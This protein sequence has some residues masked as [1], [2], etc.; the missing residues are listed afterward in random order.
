MHSF[1]FYKIIDN[2]S[3]YM[4]TYIDDVKNISQKCKN[5]C[6]LMWR[7]PIVYNN[8][9]QKV[10]SN[11][12]DVPLKSFPMFIY[13]HLP[14]GTGITPKMLTSDDI[15]GVKYILKPSKDEYSG[16]DDTYTNLYNSSM[17]TNT[18][19]MV[20]DLSTLLSPEQLSSV[21]ANG[22]AISINIPPNAQYQITAIIRS[23]V[24]DT[25]A[26]DLCIFNALYLANLNGYTYVIIEYNPAV[27]DFCD[28]LKNGILH[29]SAYININS[30]I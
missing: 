19:N 6:K 22:I 29:Y 14:D 13:N 23:T 24:S 15:N 1:G 16:N 28:Q 4:Q 5:K 3:I 20:S 11:I 26:L 7:S 10:S 27:S 12:N 21:P 9:L 18:A 17:Q 30:N 8:A 2:F 25:T